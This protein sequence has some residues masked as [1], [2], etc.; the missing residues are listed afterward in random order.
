MTLPQKD[1][2][3]FLNCRTA[4]ALTASSNAACTCPLSP[5]L[6]QQILWDGLFRPQN[7]MTIFKTNDG[8]SIIA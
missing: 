4:S 7:M 3:S 2:G 5:T 1:F 8:P 6:E